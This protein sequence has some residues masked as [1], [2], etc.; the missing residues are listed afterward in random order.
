M[1]QK[2]YTDSILLPVFCIIGSLLILTLLGILDPFSGTMSGAGGRVLRFGI[3]LLG[4]SILGLPL[5][6]IMLR[7]RRVMIQKTRAE[8]NRCLEM[9][10]ILPDTDNLSLDELAVS[11]GQYYEQMSLKFLRT[12]TLRI[13]VSTLIKQIA[14]LITQMKDQAK[15]VE[16]MTDVLQ[17]FAGKIDQTGEMSS[18]QATNISSLVNLITSMINTA[19]E[20]SNRIQEAIRESSS[21]AD[22]SLESQKQLGDITDTMLTAVQDTKNISTV[23]S[24]IDEISDKINLLSL[25]ASIEAARAGEAG[26]GFA[27]VAEEISKLAD[28]TAQSVGN[29]SKMIV[30]KS[31]QLEENIHFIQD[32]V[33]SVEDVLSR[34]NDVNEELKR[35]ARSVSDQTHLNSIV[36]G[37]ANKINTDSENIDDAITEQKVD[38]YDILTH[39]R[40]ILESTAGNREIHE[41]IETTMGKIENLLESDSNGSKT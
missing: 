17:Q 30:E 18:T 24:V 33:A 32:A 26:R 5:P 14:E 27:V 6:L 20:L 37:E 8:M 28:Q 9:E 23:L 13:H 1:K 35:I 12:G 38:I 11:L 3:Y 39:I 40:R 15:S 36:S 2:L 21:V 19:E 41:Q 7:T 4:A 22:E 10:E 31:D 16:H 34:I 29:I 25:N